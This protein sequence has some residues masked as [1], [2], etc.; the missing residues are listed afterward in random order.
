M[1]WAAVRRGGLI[2][3][4]NFEAVSSRNGAEVPSDWDIGDEDVA[5]I[6]TQAP[7]FPG[8]TDGRC[9]F[10]RRAR[11]GGVVSQRLMLAPGAYSL[12]FRAR[13]GEGASVPLRWR[14]RCSASDASQIS[15]EQPAISSK[16]REFSGKLIVPNQDCAIQRLALERPGDMH[17]PE[18]WIDDV[19]LKPAIQ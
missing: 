13:S 6:A 12:T 8:S 17:P 9:E 1:L 11:A 4:G 7:E 10:P 19:K 15:P 14:L 2:A 3:N 18:V 5:T 16:W